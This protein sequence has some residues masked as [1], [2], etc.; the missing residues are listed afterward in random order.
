M[1]LAGVIT[2]LVYQSKWTLCLKPRITVSIDFC[3]YD[4]TLRR[5]VFEDAKG[6]LTRDSRTKYAWL[7]EKYGV[8]VILWKG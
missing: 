8:G 7:N 2:D 3:Y 1:Q 4:L 5:E 6:V